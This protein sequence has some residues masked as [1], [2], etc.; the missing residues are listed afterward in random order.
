MH[1]S[2]ILGNTE[3]IG[4]VKIGWSREVSFVL[5]PFK[6]LKLGRGGYGRGDKREGE[7]EKK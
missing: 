6:G 4:G 1:L 5:C 3:A 7:E 2:R